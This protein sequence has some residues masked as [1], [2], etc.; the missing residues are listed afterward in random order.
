MENLVRCRV[1]L[2]VRVDVDLLGEL[3]YVPLISSKPRKAIHCRAEGGRDYVTARQ[4]LVEAVGT[5]RSAAQVA[6]A[7]TRT[8]QVPRDGR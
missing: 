3:L 1:L 2:W 4:P 6:C 8:A 5:F 7:A